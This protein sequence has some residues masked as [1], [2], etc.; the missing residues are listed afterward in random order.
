MVLIR[1][2]RLDNQLD[3]GRRPQQIRDNVGRARQHAAF[4]QDNVGGVA[5]DGKT[6]IVNG[7][8]LRYHAQIVLQRKYLADA[9]PINRL[10]IR[11]DNANSPRLH[12]SVK[13]LAV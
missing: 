8:G 11:N 7:I 6:Q 12:R 10:R 2:D 9:D 3:V 5:L 13:H 1:L 4:K